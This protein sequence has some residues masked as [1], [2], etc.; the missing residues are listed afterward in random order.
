MR[1]FTISTIMLLAA[2]AVVAEEHTD[3]VTAQCL[4]YDNAEDVCACATETLAGGEAAEDIALYGAIGEAA[5]S[6]RAEGA[7]F[8][9]A[10]TEAIDEVAASEGMSATALSTLNTRIAQAHRDAIGHCGG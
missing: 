10:F 9:T 7:D 2:G 4:Y 6:R 8:M 1:T 5:L 3:G